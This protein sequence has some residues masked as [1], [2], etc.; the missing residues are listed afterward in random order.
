MSH[1][2]FHCPL[3]LYV[4]IGVTSVNVDETG[5]SSSSS[6]VATVVGVTV[7]VIVLLCICCPLGII[8]IVVVVCLCC[9]RKRRRAGGTSTNASSSPPKTGSQIPMDNAGDPVP[10]YNPDITTAG[11][12]TNQPI[13]GTILTTSYPAPSV[14]EPALQPLH[15]SQQPPMLPY[16][17]AS[18]DLP[19]AYNSVL[20]STTP[21]P[22]DQGPPPTTQYH[23]YASADP[24]TPSAPAGPHGQ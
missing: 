14:G 23:Y 22:T 2:C 18:D 16:P 12:Y 11:G 9:S 24:S 10:A 19:P 4:H 17:A 21:Y 5:T 1:V 20:A 15:T 7:A 6:N 13:L 3:S 8:I